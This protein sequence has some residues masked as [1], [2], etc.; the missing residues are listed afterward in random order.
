MATSGRTLTRDAPV[1]VACRGRAIASFNRGC[2][3]VRHLDS[4]MMI[5]LVA[6]LGEL[7]PSCGWPAS[8]SSLSDLSV[9]EPSVDE[10]DHVVPE[11]TPFAFCGGSVKS[12]CVGGFCRGAGRRPS[13]AS[14]TKK[15]GKS[16]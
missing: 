3:S 13:K 6:G 2:P 8:S 5:E 4:R 15:T 7:P 11:Y 14:F 9:I 10:V 1:Y 16:V 12:S